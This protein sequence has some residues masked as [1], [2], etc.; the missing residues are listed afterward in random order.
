MNDQECVAFLQWSLPRMRMRW[1]GFRKV[2]RQVCKRVSRRIAELGLANA[3][4][5][6]AYLK[7]ND[8][9]W[10]TLEPLCRVTISRF[11]RDRGAWEAIGKHVLP[12]AAAAASERG[13]NTIRCW[14]AGC[15]SGEEP[16]TLAIL[17]W[18]VVAPTLASSIALEVV[19]TDT[20]EHVLE[21]ARTARYPWSVVKELPA[22]LRERAFCEESRALVLREEFRDGV[23]FV[24]QD[25]R[26]ALPT[27]AFDIVL[28][29]NLTF[30]YFDEELQKKVLDSIETVLSPTGI[31]VI[32]NHESLPPDTKLQAMENIPCARTHR[33]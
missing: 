18:L 14:S 16:Y 23:T 24:R 28:C 1:A 29:R 4:D 2:R 8:D 13:D 5:Y 11:Y 27:G 26:E 12:R 10:R 6:R 33:A 30:T 32:G 15:A 21:R 25:I 20:D 31:L 3:A 9:E 22:A 7:T 19:A 17:W